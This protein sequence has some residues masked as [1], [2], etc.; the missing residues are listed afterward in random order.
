MSSVNAVEAEADRPRVRRGL[1]VTTWGSTLEG[2]RYI[3]T[4]DEGQINGRLEDG[5]GR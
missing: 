1:L 4:Q 3:S 2:Q 5:Q